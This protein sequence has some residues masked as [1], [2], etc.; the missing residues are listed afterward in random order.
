MTLLSPFVQAAILLDQ[1]GGTGKREAN[2]QIVRW[3]EQRQT[4]IVICFTE[5]GQMRS[6]SQHRSRQERLLPVLVVFACLAGDALLA[7]A[8][9]AKPKATLALAVQPPHTVPRVQPSPEQIGD[10]MLLAEEQ[11]H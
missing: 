7:F 6:V 8:Q 2:G 1:L 11:G 4:A 10:S 9:Q 3:S 5:G